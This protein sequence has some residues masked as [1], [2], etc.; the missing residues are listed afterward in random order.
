MLKNAAAVRALLL[1]LMLASAPAFAGEES[2][3]VPTLILEV[4]GEGS[5]V[6]RKSRIEE[7][8]RVGAHVYP[9]E[10]VATGPRSTVKLITADGSVVKLGFGTRLQLEE[11]TVHDRGL[12]WAANLLLGQI[13]ALVVPQ[14]APRDGASRFRLRTSS[15]SLGV[16]GT[17]FVAAHY[18]E[19]ET[20]YLYALEGLLAFGQPGCEKSRTCLEVRAGE[21]SVARKGAPPSKP[22]AFDVNELVRGASAKEEDQAARLSLFKPANQA[23]EPSPGSG[24]SEM[25]KLVADSSEEL[26]AGQDKALGRTREER[27]AIQQSVKSGEIR[28]VMQA[29]DGYLTANARSP[30]DFGGAEEIVGSTLVQK[31]RLGSAVL[32]ATK[33]GLFQT[34]RSKPTPSSYMLK[35]NVSPELTTQLK[36]TT[37]TLDSSSS[38][39][40]STLATVPLKTIS[41]TTSVSATASGN[42]S[43]TK[44]STTTLGGSTLLAS[45]TLI[46]NVT[47]LAEATSEPVI[48]RYTGTTLARTA[49][50]QRTQVS[51]STS[52]G[53]ACYTTKETCKLVPCDQYYQGKTC[54][55]GSKTVCTTTKVPCP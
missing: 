42:T 11:S 37:K 30:G 38:S 32:T 36:T 4:E 39:Y 47:L 49:T 19:S 45:P 7:S 54:K 8:A 44:L 31:H 41:A 3:G 33:T 26:A 52:T 5:T 14:P 28:S 25:K 15:A 40:T 48:S 21:A 18:A 12:L 24:Q 46:S 17:E 43:V 50:I 27:I 13:R 10:T 51:T 35:K 2:A 23:A 20:T 53:T 22:A 9:G 29:A 16:R 6:R 55:G 1:A 34:S